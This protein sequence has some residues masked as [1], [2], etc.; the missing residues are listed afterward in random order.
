[1]DHL[2]VTKCSLFRSDAP[3]LLGLQ[4]N[5]IHNLRDALRIYLESQ[6]EM[7]RVIKEQRPGGPL[8]VSYNRGNNKTKV[9]RRYD[10][11]YVTPD[12]T[13]VKVEYLELLSEASDHALVIAELE[14]PTV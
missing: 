1:M 10:H 11:I 9:D 14:I 5:P 2:D 12:L 7:V 4:S 6:P 13:V 3:E 8:A